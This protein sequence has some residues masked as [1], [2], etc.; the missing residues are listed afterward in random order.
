MKGR[1]GEREGF[2]KNE[3]EKEVSRRMRMKRRR[4]SR[5]MMGFEISA[6]PRL[7]GLTRSCWPRICSE[8]V[9]TDL[10][11]ASAATSTSTSI[12]ANWAL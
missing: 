7:S 1:V 6:A 8:T 5:K 3:D 11:F 10:I 12:T 2:S 9:L 4:V